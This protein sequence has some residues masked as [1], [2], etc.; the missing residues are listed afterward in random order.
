MLPGGR[1]HQG[2]LMA[3]DV[4]AFLLTQPSQVSILMANQHCVNV[5][6]I[7]H[8][9]DLESNLS[10]YLSSEQMARLLHAGVCISAIWASVPFIT[11]PQEGPWQVDRPLENMSVEASVCGQNPRAH[12]PHNL[13]EDWGGTWPSC[14]GATS[15]LQHWC[16]K[17][18]QE[19]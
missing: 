1:A 9:G 17:L 19:H 10:S 18:V 15:S 8:D 11:E 16:P 2:L 5:N 7:S 6:T 4:W 14:H 13:S 12:V 3:A